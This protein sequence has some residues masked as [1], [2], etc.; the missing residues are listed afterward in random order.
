MHISEINWGDDSAERDPSLLDY[1]VAS[2]AFQRLRL[3]SKSIVVGRKG[4]GKS[5]LRKKLEQTFQLQDD[6]YVVNLSPNFNSIRNILNDRD[7]AEN[8]CQEIFFQH[9][10]L[11]QILLD[12]L[13]KVGH[14]AR[15]KYAANSL[16]FARGVSVQLNRTSKDL[17]ENV[18]DILGRLKGKAGSLGEFGLTLEREL[19]NV[20]EVDSL[21]HHLRNI[22]NS[23]AKFVILVDDLDLGWNNSTVANNLLLGLLAAINHLSDLS[24]N[25]Y[26]CVFLRED[27][28][29]I[30]ITQTQHSDKY[31]NIERIRWGKDDLLRILNERINFNRQRSNL[32]RSDSPFNTVFPTTVGT[33]N[34]DN[35]LLERTLGRPRE[36]IQLARYYTEGVEGD[37]PSDEALKSSEQG[38]SSWKLDDLCTEYSNQYPGLISIF[39]YWKTK[40]FR[41]KYH[42]KRAE[43][44]EMLLCIA[45]DVALNE[46]WFNSV[47]GTTD[48]DA[49]L[50]VLYEIGF[51][52]DYVQ[53]GEGGSKT[54]YSYLDRHEPRFEEV[55]IHPCF[56]RAVNTVERIRAK[57]AAQLLSCEGGNESHPKT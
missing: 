56:R 54:F 13:C 8:F 37:D 4:S 50:K 2:D 24:E 52:G 21:E 43:I 53:G 40:F 19:R 10:W 34:T 9:T 22:A 57:A 32:A 25:L 35:W 45:T 29:S 18:A 44:E 41:H 30:L 3:K 12:C 51:I 11:R 26:V 36:L 48:I 14:N 7:I 31:R 16:D 27:V 15:G 17:V 39:S 5:A 38:Y 1:F 46:E 20:A 47:V 28:Y 6:T 49:F 23:G 42:L 33:S 55:Q